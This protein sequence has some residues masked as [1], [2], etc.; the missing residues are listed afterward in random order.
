MSRCIILCSTTSD[1]CSES[2]LD[3][4]SSSFL[5]FYVMGHLLVFW[6]WCPY[7]LIG[8]RRS[9]QLSTQTSSWPWPLCSRP[10]SN[11]ITTGNQVGNEQLYDPIFDYQWSYAL[12]AA[13]ICQQLQL[14]GIVHETPT[15]PVDLGHQLVD[16]LKIAYMRWII[17]SL[18]R[19]HSILAYALFLNMLVS[20]LL[21][22]AYI[23]SSCYSYNIT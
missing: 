18:M 8:S 7:R 13:H 21:H 19:V 22:M 20:S 14:F 3:R 12:I 1:C 9:R 2:T 6:S 23:C 15:G 4:M 5:S 17:P 10:L 11:S 16:C